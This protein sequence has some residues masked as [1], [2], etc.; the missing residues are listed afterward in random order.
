MNK[1]KLSFTLIV[2]GGLVFYIWRYAR[3]DFAPKTPTKVIKTPTK[4]VE[5]PTKVTNQDAGYVGLSL[6]ARDKA[7]RAESLVSPIQQRKP[8]PK[9]H[10]YKFMAG[11]DFPGGDK[12]CGEY[13]VFNTDTFK[14]VCDRDPSCKGFNALK[15]S[16]TT[17]LCMKTKIGT[18]VQ[19]SNVNF[20]LKQQS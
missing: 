2:G 10:A 17:P 4:V 19:S 15:T 9:K 6:L 3:G 12:G 1:D 14:L 20:Y 16:P 7:P 5:A 8:I 18:R 13:N 11:Y